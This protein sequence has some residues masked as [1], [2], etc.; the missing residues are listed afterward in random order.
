MGV[1][2]NNNLKGVIESDSWNLIRGEID[3]SNSQ[4]KR[5]FDCF[6]FLNHNDFVVECFFS[7][8]QS[9][10]LKRELAPEKLFDPGKIFSEH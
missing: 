2:S 6:F 9:E 5:I 8:E 7:G 1:R 4:L 3:D 10:N